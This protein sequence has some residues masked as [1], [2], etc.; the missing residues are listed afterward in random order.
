MEVI[1]G[2]RTDGGEPGGTLY[3]WA[4]A[5][6][7]QCG[8]TKEKPIVLSGERWREVSRKSWSGRGVY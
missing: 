5:Q 3:F 7:Q 8:V 1:D 6:R 4:D 2:L